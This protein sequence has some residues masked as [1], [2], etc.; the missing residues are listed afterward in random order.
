MEGRE[1]SSLVPEFGP[2]LWE[3]RAGVVS[4]ANNLFRSIGA[5]LGTVLL[6]TLS[7]L[8]LQRG[9]AYPAVVATVFDACHRARCVL[10]HNVGRHRALV[11]NSETIWTPLCI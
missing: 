5:T 11:A 10:R 9:Q 8:G 2:L 4:G 7:T 3:S 6:G 1:C